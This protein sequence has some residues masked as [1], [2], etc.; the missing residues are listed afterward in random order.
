MI[1]R[2]SEAERRQIWQAMRAPVYAF[3]SLLGLLL[4]I[5]LLGAL[6][7]GRITSYLELGIVLCMV[8]TVLLVSMEVRHEPP[9]M[10]L[11]AL[12]GFFWLAILAGM[13]MV[14]YWTR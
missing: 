5:V 14:D 3:A 4:V 11:F 2:I 9:L 10:R 6:A 8:A 1:S 12:L 13:T 7:P